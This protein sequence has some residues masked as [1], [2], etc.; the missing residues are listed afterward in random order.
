MAALQGAGIFLAT[1]FL[2]AGDL[3]TRTSVSTRQFNSSATVR[4]FTPVEPSM[5]IG[6]VTSL[7][8]A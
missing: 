5:A 2:V 3:E 6:V 7:R 4:M 8:C 1:G